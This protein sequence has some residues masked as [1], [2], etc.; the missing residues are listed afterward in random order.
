MLKKRLRCKR[1]TSML[2]KAVYAV[3]C[4]LEACEAYAL[5]ALKNSLGCFDS[6]QLHFHL[7]EGL[8]YICSQC[9]HEEANVRR[10]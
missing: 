5:L 10:V 1:D 4:P 6:H 9:L 2:D 3:R 8:L 7:V